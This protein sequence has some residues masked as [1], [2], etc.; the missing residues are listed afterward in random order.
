MQT[1]PTDRD[2]V[3]RRISELRAGASQLSR[4]L[5]EEAL[6]DDEWDRAARILASCRAERKLLED[7]LSENRPVGF[8]P[9]R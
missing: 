6:G 3:R 2:A 7:C 9:R 5:A 4:L 8:S 1:P